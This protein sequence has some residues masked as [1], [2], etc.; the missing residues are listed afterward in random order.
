VEMTL[1]AGRKLILILAN[2]ARNSRPM[3]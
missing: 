3:M 1:D 2:C